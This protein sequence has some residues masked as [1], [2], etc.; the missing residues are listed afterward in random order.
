VWGSVECRVCPAG[1]A[2][3][4]TRATCGECTDPLSPPA[5]R[6]ASPHKGRI[7]LWASGNGATNV[8]A[9]RV[10]AGESAN[11]LRTLKTYRSRGFETAIT[12][13]TAAPY[14]QVQAI[15]RAELCSVAPLSCATERAAP[16]GDGGAVLTGDSRP[17]FSVQTT[18]SR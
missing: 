14:V 13:P 12:A 9:W 17:V 16:R 10:R 15:S 3:A 11:A 1:A 4:G 2:Q 7:A 18:S 8:A 6:A 5:L